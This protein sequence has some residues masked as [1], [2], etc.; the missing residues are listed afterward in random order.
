MSDP[1]LQVA[2]ISRRFGGLVAVAGVSFAAQSGEIFGLIGPNGAGKTTILNI[3]A[4]ALPPSSGQVSFNGKDISRLPSSARARLG[5]GRTFQAAS[6]FKEETVA[7]NVRRGYLLKRRGRP[8]DFL[9]RA[10]SNRS[11]ATEKEAIERAVDFVGLR[12]HMKALA[13]A[14]P[15]G[16]QKLVGLAIALAAGPS[17]LLMDEPAAGLNPSETQ[18]LTSLIRRLPAELGLTI[19]LVEHDMKMVMQIC[20]RILVLNYG[21]E[22]CLGDPSTVRSNPMVIEAY[23]GGEYE[24][25]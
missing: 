23:L 8:L 5:I 21:R 12:D 15:Y 1:V 18:T 17:L 11:H 24:F 25:A 10:A 20:D 4:G 9:G 3:L 19:V 6:T 2:G 7:E 14:L 22:I 13:G 16:L